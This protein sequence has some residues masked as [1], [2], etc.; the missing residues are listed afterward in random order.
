MDISI[1]TNINI[2]KDNLVNLIG[3]SNL[4]IGVTYYILKDIFLEIQN[5]YNETLNKE[6]QEILKSISEE[7]NKPD[8]TDNNKEEN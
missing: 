3:N 6:Q 5:I 7:E 2:F 8:E 4:P 1:N